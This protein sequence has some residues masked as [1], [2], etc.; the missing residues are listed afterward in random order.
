VRL[1]QF[2]DHYLKGEPMP[3]W[4]ARGRNALDKQKTMSTGLV[5]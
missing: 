5:R 2:F 4:M 3:E 1:A